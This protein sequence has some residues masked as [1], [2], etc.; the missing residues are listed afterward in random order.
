MTTPPTANS[1]SNN[2]MHNCIRLAVKKP[3]LS[4]SLSLRFFLE[5]FVSGGPM[6][7]NSGTSTSPSVALLLLERSRLLVLL[8]ER[9]RPAPLLLLE[10]SSASPFWA[11]FIKSSGSF[12]SLSGLRTSKGK[13][14]KTESWADGDRLLL[15]WPDAGSR[16]GEPR[17]LGE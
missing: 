3:R 15:E 11:R 6:S 8:L 4:L 9:S 14:G 1:S 17:V 16:L 10:W 2:K 13:G 5:F 7:T 12:G